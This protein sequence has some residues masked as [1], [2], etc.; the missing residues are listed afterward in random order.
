M[1]RALVLTLIGL[2]FLALAPAVAGCGA[3]SEIPG[4]DSSSQTPDCD[5]ALPT[6]CLKCSDGSTGCPHWV[7]VDGQCTVALCDE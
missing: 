2:P 1:K 7:I 3:A 4:E 5:D 6:F